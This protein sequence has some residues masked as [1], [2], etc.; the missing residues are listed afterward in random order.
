VWR[1]GIPQFI[2]RI[3]G[4]TYVPEPGVL[5]L[6]GMGL[7]GMGLARRRKSERRLFLSVHPAVIR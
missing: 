2:G 4:N 1:R 6:L 7:L 3:V 5:A